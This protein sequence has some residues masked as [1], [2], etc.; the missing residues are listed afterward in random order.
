MYY[1]K[2][3]SLGGVL[4]DDM[5][6]GKTVQVAVYLKGLFDA[7][8]I[9]RVLIVVPATLKTY[10]E[11]EL[12]KWCYDCP[13]VVRFEDSK[14]SVRADQMKTIRRKGGILL[15][16]FGMITTERQN[17]QDMSYD[18]MIIDEGHKAKNKDTQFRRDITSLKVK[19]H[20]MILTGTPLQNN[21]SELWSIFDIVQPKIFGSS[22][23]FQR[24]YQTK[25]E[26]G[27][28][29]D[30][31]DREKN[32]AEI[33]SEQ[34]REKYKEHFL[35][36]T[37]DNIFKIVCSETLKRPLKIDELPIKT[38]LVIWMPLSPTQKKIYQFMLENAD[39]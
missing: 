8:L 27:L 17:L 31:S 3:K 11:D 5:G 21:L 37:K 36:R 32:M 14:K 35:R 10:W 16:S 24:E 6:L 4:G 26:R 33:L 38:D 22:D 20:R 13:N 30:S 25:I 28:L 29:K 1:L 19:S 34:L 2:Q 9:K 18:I 15:S 39:L 12:N 23:R 7:E